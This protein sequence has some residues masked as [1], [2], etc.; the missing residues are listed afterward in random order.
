[1]SVADDP[2]SGGDG[3]LGVG[4][5]VDFADGAG[6]GSGLD[7]G[8][9]GGPDVDFAGGA[10]RGF[11]PGVGV[12][13]D[14]NF[15]D[16][17]MTESATITISLPPRILSPNRPPMTVGG[18]IGKA[19]AAKAYRQQTADA[20]RA[21]GIETFPWDHA[22]VSPTVFWPDRRRRDTDNLIGAI[23]SV[24]DGLV[25]GGVVPDDDPAHMTR[26]EP[27]FAVDRDWP[28]IDLTLE[29]RSAPNG[30]PSD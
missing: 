29:R 9:D 2:V 13:N 26:R 19:K 16:G 1:M 6:F 4:N 5:D 23:K 20:V 7:C 30:S 8:F 24:Y 12:G 21:A 18:R 27:T 22:V 15:A 14:V 28:R 3:G 17:E 10:D 11:G 25:D